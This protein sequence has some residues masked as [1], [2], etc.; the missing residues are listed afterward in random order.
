MLKG[1]STQT[2]VLHRVEVAPPPGTADL[3]ASA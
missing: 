3:V 1:I 2:Q